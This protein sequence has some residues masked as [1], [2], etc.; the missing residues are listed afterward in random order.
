MS[1]NTIVGSFS[2]T[3]NDAGETFTYSLVNGMGGTDNNNFNI[4]GN[5]LRTNIVLNYTNKTSHNIRVRTSDANGCYFEQT[6]TITVN[7]VNTAPTEIFI[8]DS[9]VNENSPAL[10]VIGSFSTLDNDIN[11]SYTY[12]LV[13][14]TG[15]TNNSSFNIN[16]TN[17]RTTSIFNQEIKSS[18]SIRV[19]VTDGASN[20]FER[21]FT[22]LVDDVNDFPTDIKIN[23]NGSGTNFAE[24][25]ALGSLVGYLST[26]DEDLNNTFT[27]SFV[28]VS[29]NNNSDFSIVGSQLRTNNLFDYE[30]RQNYVVFVQT[31]DG[32]GGSFTKQLLLQVV[33]SNDAPNSINLTNTSISENLLTNTFVAKLSANDPD[34]SS[35][36]SFSLVNGTGS[37]GN[38]NFTIRNDSLFSNTSFDYETI[39]SYSIRLNVSDGMGGAYQQAFPINVLNS[40]D[41]PSDININSN[42]IA[43]NVSTNTVIGSLSTADQD[44]N[45]TFIYT[46]VS[47]SGSADNSAFNISGNNL[48]SSSSFDFETKSSYSIR[49]RSTDNGGAYFEKIVNIQVT[50]VIDAPTNI[51][52]SN[53]TINENLSSNTLIGNLT[54]VSQD[55]SPSFSFSFDNNMP[56][57]DNSSFVLV[58][59]QLRSNSTFN[60]ESKSIYTIY[61]TASSGASSTFTKLI[62]IFIRNQNDAPTD[63]SLSFN[64]I[65]ENRPSASFIGIFSSSDADVNSTFSYSLV[66]GIGATDNVSF[67]VRN[68]SLFTA[69][70]LDFETKNS[71][72]IR[73]QT[74]DNGNQSF[75]KAFT[76]MVSDSNDAPTSLSLST[77]ALNENLTAGSVIANISTVDSDAGQSHTY[78]LVGGLGSDN[79]N[80]FNI[81]GNQLRSSTSFNYEV[82][83]TYKIRIQ[84]N[85]GNGGTKSD[86]FSIY[87]LNANDVPS[88]I[89]LSNDAIVENRALNSFV[90]NLNTTDEDAGNFFVYSFL[91]IAG[92]D[93]ASFY[94]NG[95]QLRT[96]AQFD[97]ENKQIYTVFIQTSDGVST[98]S[99]QFVINIQDSNDAPTNI[100]LSNNTVSENLTTNSFIGMLYSTDVDVNNTFNYTL[101]SGNGST[102]NSDFIVRNDS[103]LTGRTFNFENKSSYSI[104]LRTTDNGSLFYE[105][106]FQIIINDANDVP[107]DISLSANEITENR[108]SR[109]YIGVF[110]TS[111]Q[112][113][114]NNF[115]YSLSSGAGDTDNA[116]FVLIGN[117]LRSNRIF[118]YENK[119]AYSI[120]VQSNDGN[121]GYIEKIFSILISDSNDAPSNILLG[122]QIIAENMPIAS[123]VCDISTVDQDVNDNFVYSFSNISGNNNNN[124]FIIGNE[125]RTNMVF[126]YEVKNFYIVVLTATDAS[127]IS[128]NKQFVI[129]IKDSVDAPTSLELG[130]NSISENMPIGEVVGT[131]TATDADQFSN[132]NY[133]LVSGTGSVDNVNF[134]I[135]NDTLF[136]NSSFNFEVKKSYSIRVR[137]TDITNAS[138]EK[139]FNIEISDAN[140]APTGLLLSNNNLDENKPALTEIGNFTTQD[141][142]ANETHK[143]SFVSGV[144]ATDNPLFILEGNT[145]RSNFT[146]NFEAKNSYSIRVAT[147]DNGGESLEEVFVISIMDNSEKPSINDQEFFV[148][149]NDSIG[150]II[151]T[152]S[153]N[154]P[155]ATANLTFSTIGQN[156]FFTIDSTTGNIKVKQKIDYEKN[157]AVALIIV[158]TDM[159]A[160][161]MYDTAIASIFVKDEIELNQPLPVNNYLSPN[162]DKINDYFSIDNPEL[163]T[164][165]NLSVFN[166]SGM[167]V[168]SISGNYQNNW[169]GTYQGNKLPTG[170][171][172]Y[173]F[174]NNKTGAKFRGALNIVNQ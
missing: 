46:L 16:G 125:L 160:V 85:D 35:I 62:Q 67:F 64:T 123:K 93:N 156:S 107:S 145:L 4:S 98:F 65:R 173:V 105:K 102:N 77:N 155:D 142:D 39:T 21:I 68:D 115:S 124:F 26:T 79:N 103:L 104:R 23:N 106:I 113:P 48:R 134:N 69:T 164:D 61:I 169:D 109:T 161:P 163:Y 110:N 111:D 88:A 58:G 49:L 135:V 3:D 30:T 59:N 2:S 139:A 29:G 18:Y 129:Q 25:K 41:T 42:Q 90:G 63:I 108:S 7:D 172:F 43:E 74:T 97:F 150:T 73:T 32:M 1:I 112:D 78:S 99:K 119:S 168:Y 38:S 52:I 53:D 96:N 137:V 86:T 100:V 44:A 116:A 166:E 131:F 126:D 120:R 170:V 28:D 51:L 24:N 158:V 154:S 174:S 37:S 167:E 118:N 9:T 14:G 22:I 95:N 57:N 27:Y 36:H 92:N 31:N 20:T 6:F 148:S 147:T 80:M 84:T 56:G 130:D 171:Y 159:Q 82:K 143:Y 114:T 162:G 101:V 89:S 45:N 83:S 75:Q 146:A 72:S 127:G 54:G 8:S 34:V 136:A 10:T 157:N 60:F 94:I 87:I 81:V 117:E 5:S 15:S 13:S 55:A 128:Y 122:T 50:D 33:D 71:Y 140:D 47:G 17:L 165:Y 144:G 66:N 12:T 133:S 152:L 151:G 132:F 91:N 138:F 40:N 70:L 149:E 121:G 76:I 153:S 19:R 11:D 141:I